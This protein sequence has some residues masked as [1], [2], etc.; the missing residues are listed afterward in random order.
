M[1]EAAVV[2]CPHPVKGETVF[3]FIVF[4]EAVSATRAEI[5]EQLKKD[6]KKSIAGYAVPEFMLVSCCETKLL[7]R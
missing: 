5:V 2:G 7:R 4:K 3:A 6:V 1:S